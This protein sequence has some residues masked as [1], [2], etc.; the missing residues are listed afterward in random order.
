[1]S[2]PLDKPIRLKPQYAGVYSLAPAGA[3]GYARRR[4]DDEGFPLVFVEWDKD[5]WSYSG[6]PDVWTFENHFEP[7][8]ETTK[9]S[10]DGKGKLP[11]GLQE[12][13]E[14]LFADYLAKQQGEGSTQAEEPTKVELPESDLFDLD[15]DESYKEIA[16]KLSEVANDAIAFCLIGVAQSEYEGGEALVP[17][18]VTA[19]KDE[20]GGIVLETQ[21]AQYGA[22]GFQNAAV[23]LI[24]RLRDE[25]KED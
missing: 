6:E 14:E 1:M 21:V 22:S 17:F 24:N 19:I 8:E 25:K 15:T 10:A 20:I 18:V 4:K 12:G 23:A 11:P 7:V 2:L 3:Q 5:H 13:I 9:M 16:D